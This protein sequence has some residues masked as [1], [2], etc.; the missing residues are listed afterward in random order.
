[1]MR[2]A[3]NLLGQRVSSL[4]IAIDVAHP[5]RL[6]VDVLEG[7]HQIALLSCAN[8]SPSVIRNSMSR[9]CALSMVG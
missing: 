4:G 7:R 3:D 6:R 5:E 1:M 2:I 8:V 9:T